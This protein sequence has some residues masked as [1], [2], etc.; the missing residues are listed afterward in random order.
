MAT[1]EI[2]LLTLGKIQTLLPKQLNLPRGY[3]M[4]YHPAHTELCEKIYDES[5]KYSFEYMDN[6]SVDSI[7]IYKEC[8]VDWE[9]IDWD[10]KNVKEYEEYRRNRDNSW[11]EY[12]GKFDNIKKEFAIKE[13]RD[14]AP[15]SIIPQLEQMLQVAKERCL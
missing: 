6:I 3:Q 4:A 13:S 1:G 14:F 10:H 9:F 7:T 12:Y 15:T 11:D 5:K 8:G 2:E